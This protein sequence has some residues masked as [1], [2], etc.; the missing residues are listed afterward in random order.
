M[1]P[2]PANPAIIKSSDY[3]RVQSAR[4]KYSIKPE[5]RLQRSAYKHSGLT[6][7]HEGDQHID[8]ASPDAAT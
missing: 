3:G 8:P 6:A 4:L 2:E 5:R 7:A 1:F